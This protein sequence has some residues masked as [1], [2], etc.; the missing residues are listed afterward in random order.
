MTAYYLLKIRKVL[1]ALVVIQ[2][3]RTLIDLYYLT[4]QIFAIW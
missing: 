1:V 3:I 2:L 4:C